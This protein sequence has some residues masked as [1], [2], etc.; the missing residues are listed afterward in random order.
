MINELRERPPRIL[1]NDHISDFEALLHKSNDISSH[2]RI[3]RMNFTKSKMNFPINHGFSVK[4]EK[5]YLQFPNFARGSV[6]KKE[7]YFCGL[8]CLSYRAPQP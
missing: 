5:Y 7:N 6:R 2:H 1:L 4:Q 8:E 3:L